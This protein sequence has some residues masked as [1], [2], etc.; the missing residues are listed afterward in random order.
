MLLPTDPTATAEPSL[1][2]KYVGMMSG[3]PALSENQVPSKLMVNHH[4]IILDN[5]VHCG[6]YEAL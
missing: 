2:L 6:N 4:C 3:Y 1:R 5:I